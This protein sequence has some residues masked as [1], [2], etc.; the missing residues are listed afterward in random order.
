MIRVKMFTESQSWSDKE[1]DEKINQFLIENPGIEFVD[2]K[3]SK[4]ANGSCVALLIYKEKG[5]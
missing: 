3:L 4:V 2:I 5:E 1:L